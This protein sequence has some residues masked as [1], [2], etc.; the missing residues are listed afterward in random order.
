M[1]LMIRLEL[2][3]NVENVSFLQNQHTQCQYH[4]E[5]SLKW[6]ERRCID[7]DLTFYNPLLSSMH[8][9]G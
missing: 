2:Q 8:G 7:V 5:I 6:E 4:K 1:L 9:S 3:K